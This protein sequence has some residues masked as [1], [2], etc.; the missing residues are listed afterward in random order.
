MKGALLKGGVDMVRGSRPGRARPLTPRTSILHGWLVVGAS[1][2]AA[3][4]AV[5]EPVRGDVPL[6]AFLPAHAAQTV[7][8]AAC[9][10]LSL[11]GLGAGRPLERALVPL[12]FLGWT[13]SKHARLLID[14][15][16]DLGLVPFVYAS[17]FAAL[18]LLLVR[19]SQGADPPGGVAA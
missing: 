1:L 10:A 11:D 5:Q 2:A 6:S 9:I 19:C 16:G 4:L 13:P 12:G 18:A 15:S 17:R 7:A 8:Y 14:L 3:A